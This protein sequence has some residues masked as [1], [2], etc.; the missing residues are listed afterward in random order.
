MAKKETKPEE[1]PYLIPDLEK[2]ITLE[3]C[4]ARKEDKGQYIVRV[5]LDDQLLFNMWCDRISVFATKPPT[6]CLYAC[7]INIVGL[8]AK[9]MTINPD[10]EGVIPEATRAALGKYV[11]VGKI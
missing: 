10:V 9:L 4:S 3:L 5:F 7:G 2:R 11:Q 6:Y 8:H 1:K